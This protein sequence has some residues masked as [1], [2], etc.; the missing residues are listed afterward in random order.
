MPDRNDPNYFW[1]EK[2]Y[3]KDEDPA[4]DYPFMQRKSSMT[5]SREDEGQLTGVDK[6]FI[7]G[8]ALFAG[9]TILGLINSAGSK[10]KSKSKR[11]RRLRSTRIRATPES[12][13]QHIWMK[14]GCGSRLTNRLRGL[15]SGDPL[16]TGRR[17]GTYCST[18]RSYEQ[19]AAQGRV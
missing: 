13:T 14:E 2:K 16:Y 10:S 3:G 9:G 18:R 11:R 5:S 15:R 12:E 17:Q 6:T 7:A 8:V 19:K 1:M 4:D